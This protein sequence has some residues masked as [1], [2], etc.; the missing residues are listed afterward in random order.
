MFFVSVC[1]LAGVCVNP[2]ELIL[3]GPGDEGHR[4]EAARAARDLAMVQVGV[5]M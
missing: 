2:V 4:Y 3:S 1:L 5:Q